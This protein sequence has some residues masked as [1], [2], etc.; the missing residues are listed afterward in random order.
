LTGLGLRAVVE[1]APAVLG[2]VAVAQICFGQVSGSISGYIRDASN[3]GIP[4]AAIA[5]RSTEQQLT[6][7]TVTDDSG[8]Y[9]LLAVPSGSFEVSA[10]ADGF[11]KQIQ[12]G[13]RLSLGEN[14]RL[15]MTLKIGSV[16]SEVTEQHGPL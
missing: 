3:A 16:Q 8:F 9:N 14:L 2:Y 13:V 6:R 1:G 11:Q 12:S 4:R 5:A 10:A 7:T 15:D